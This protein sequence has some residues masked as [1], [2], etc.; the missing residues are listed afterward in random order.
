MDTN[1]NIVP[2]LPQLDFDLQDFSLPRWKIGRDGIFTNTM[3]GERKSEI[4]AAVV[5]VARSRFYWPPQYSPDNLPVCYSTNSIYPS[6]DSA[7]ICEHCADCPEQEW[8]KL[9]GKTIKPNCSISYDYLIYDLET[10]I[11]SVLSLSRSRVST[12][13]ALN[14]MFQTTGVKFAIRF[15]TALEKSSNGIEFFNVSFRIEGKNKSYGE[16][17]R[18]MLEN[19]NTPLCG[20]IT[21]GEIEEELTENAPD[22]KIDF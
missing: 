9:N 10:E 4:L 18:L 17:V 21:A 16:Y 14:S 13:R 22:E 11:P 2:E 3:T 8:K 20:L 5:K 6:P 19:R 12:A 7:Q 15:F 1:N